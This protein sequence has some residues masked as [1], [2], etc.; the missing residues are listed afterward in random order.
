MS[1]TPPP[2]P[3]PPPP[4]GGLTPPPAYNGSTEVGHG[5]LRIASLSRV[6][7]ILMAVEAGLQLISTYLS[8]QL[9]GKAADF[10]AGTITEEQF[11]S[12]AQSPLTSMAGLLFLPIA[13]LTIFWMFRMASN[14]RAINR[15]GLRWAPMWAILGWLLPPCIIFVL[16]WLILGELWRASDPDA[17]PYD[18][19]WKRGRTTPLIHAWWVLYGLLPLVGIATSASMFRQFQQDDLLEFA[20][21]QQQHTGLNIFLGLGTTAAAAVFGLLVRQLSDRHMRTTREI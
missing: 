19:S 6:L 3:P 14:L 4:P 13:A 2:P 11:K 16:P 10:V 9:S 17:A 21:Q 7:W 18:E 20:Q 8:W 5:V 1:D 12:A 15:V